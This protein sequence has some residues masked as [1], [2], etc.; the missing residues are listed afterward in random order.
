[1]SPF[2]L[3]HR[4]RAAG[5]AQARPLTLCL[6]PPGDPGLAGQCLTFTRRW[7][8]CRKYSDRRR[9][10]RSECLRGAFESGGPGVCGEG[11]EV[12]WKPPGPLVPR[13]RPATHTRATTSPR[14]PNPRPTSTNGCFPG[15]QRS[16]RECASGG[17]SK[18]GQGEA[19]A[20]LPRHVACS[21]AARVRAG[22]RTPTARAHTQVA[23]VA[24]LSVPSAE[25]GQTRRAA[26]SVP[27]KREAGAERRQDVL[28]PRPG[29]RGGLG[30]AQDHLPGPQPLP[31][32]PS[33]RGGPRLQV[34]LLGSAPPT[35]T[36]F[37]G[38]QTGV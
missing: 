34:L 37:L 38:V 11:A 1:M 19:V 21:L 8:G 26:A 36:I 20:V 31:P 18:S 25:P 15:L 7:T 23:Q 32:P 10:G 27:R 33:W 16:S 13:P 2:K 6:S 9:R 22:T 12:H 4:S 30:L 24:V 29:T 3:D 5:L 28:E 14:H 17:L 35:S